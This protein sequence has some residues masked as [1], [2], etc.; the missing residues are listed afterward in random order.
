MTCSEAG[1]E[2]LARSVEFERLAAALDDG[3]F[4]LAD[5]RT[6][7]AY[8]YLRH[9]LESCPPESIFLDWFTLAVAEIMSKEAQ[10]VSVD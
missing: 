7:E 5:G 10:A 3:Q 1:Y 4:L 9:V 8:D 6:D 2:R